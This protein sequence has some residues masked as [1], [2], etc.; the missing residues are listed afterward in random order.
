MDEVY[1]RAYRDIFTACWC[2]QAGWR[3]SI[4]LISS[5]THSQFGLN[6]ITVAD[7]Q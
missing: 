6:I 2:E 5:A 3:L 1:N 7:K 4:Y